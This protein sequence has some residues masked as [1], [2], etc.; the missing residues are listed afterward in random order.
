[1]EY[2]SR[3]EQ[4]AGGQKVNVGSIDVEIEK[5]RAKSPKPLQRS[6]SEK[7]EC[8]NTKEDKPLLS[9]KVAYK[10]DLED[11]KNK[12]SAVESS[13]YSVEQSFKKVLEESKKELSVLVET[14]IEENKKQIES[15][16]VETLKNMLNES[17]SKMNE[18]LRRISEELVSNGDTVNELKS[19]VLSLEDLF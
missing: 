10:C 4:L 3:K 18:Q 12:M 17:I 6:V 7:R 8:E 5:V 2:N 11:I 16:K 9:K 14:K 15:L 19:R 13:C 1:M